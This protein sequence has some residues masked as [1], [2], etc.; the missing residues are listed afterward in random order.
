MLGYAGWHRVFPM[1][2]P[3]IPAAILVSTTLAVSAC[4]RVTES[5]KVA[6]V[7]TVKANV[8]AMQAKNMD[9]I[10]A[11]IHSQ[12]P[13][14][15]QTKMI[16]QRMFELYDIDYKLETVEVETAT[17]DT[18]RVRFAQKMS[19]TRGPEEFVSGTM[20]GVHVLRRDGGSWKLWATEP[21]KLAPSDGAD[22]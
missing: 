11:T 9:A 5:D 6:A 1:K 4:Q 16:T 14:F 21:G 20:T 17:P 13:H 22:E 19:K 7:E 2:L 12:S 3:P 10:M 18:I 15:E 8:V